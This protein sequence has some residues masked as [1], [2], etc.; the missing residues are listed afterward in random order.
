M[1]KVE[2]A[3]VK[4]ARRF[5]FKR[6]DNFREARRRIAMWVLAIGIVIGA[7]GLQFFWYQQEYRTSANAPDGTYAE[8]VLGPVDTLNPVFAKSS[9]EESAG[10]LLFSRLLTY[11]ETGN[12]NFDLADSMKVSDDQKTYTLSIRPDA[13]WSD[14][15][16]VRARDVVFTVG[17][18]Q[19]VATRSTLTGWNDV[20]VAEI[21]D[22]TVAFTLPAVYAAFPHALRFLPIL[23]EHSLRDVEPAQLRENSF[24]TKPVG[25]G[26]FTV[27]LL[28]DIDAAN[29]RKIIHLARN[30]S[31]Y[32]GAPKLSRVQL[33]VYKDA[34]SIKRALATS[35]VNAASDLPVVTADSVANERYTVENHPINSGVYALFNTANGSLSDQKVRKAL[36]AGT[37]TNAVRTSISDKL[38]ALYLPIISSQLTGELPNAPVYNPT[39]AGTLLDEAGWKLEGSV[40]VKDGQP[41]TLN[42]VTTKNPDFEKALDVL[43]A[44]WRALGITITTN[45]VDPG[46][47]SQNVAQTILQP[48]RYDVLLYQLTV[49]GDPDVYAYW[50]G[51]QVASGFNFSNYKNAAADDALSSARSRVETNLRN[52]KY[53]TFAR[54]W[55]TDA[56]AIGLYQATAQY[57]HTDGVH[58]IPAKTSLISAADRYNTVLYWT[59]GSHSVFKTP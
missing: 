56:P 5:V 49:G 3:T 52:A 39:Q 12:L 15:I 44:Q 1:K 28:Q 9:A 2:G 40:R 8:A 20:K 13:R 30:D 22:R 19:N 48:R 43:S 26:P 59:V 18:L 14:G 7:T 29:G 4:H 27:K 17:L 23:P 58:A 34:D 47:S 24:S 31:Y 6:W 16:Y 32:R 37:D 57:V 11:D 53:L 41:L 38:P 54:Q 46:D 42:I 50:H 21:D 51:S 45:I 33:H 36:Q 35:E 55:L 25:S 10:E